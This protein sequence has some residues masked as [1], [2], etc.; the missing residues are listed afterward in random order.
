MDQYNQWNFFA[1]R[2]KY[3]MLCPQF[4][5]GYALFMSDEDK[6]LISMMR[7]VKDEFKYDPHKVFLVG[8]STGAEFAQHFLFEHPGYIRAA[9][10]LAI[11]NFRE[12]PYSGE[13]RET[14]YFIGV[15]TE[16]TLRVEPTQ[17]LYEQLKK[18]GYDAFYDQFDFVGH[19][20]NDGVKNKV[21]EF[22]KTIN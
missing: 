9:A 18:N 4:F 12:P 15:G 2:D 1:N 10:I 20:L 3:I 22:L 5:G 19:D 8:F 21:M 11:A 13:G 17:R 16:D 14:Q 6:N 7:E